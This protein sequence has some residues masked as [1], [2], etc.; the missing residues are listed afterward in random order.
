MSKSSLLGSTIGVL[1]AVSVISYA[2][3]FT[4]EPQKQGPQSPIQSPAKTD[5]GS[6]IDTVS[7]QP[8]QKSSEALTSDR[9]S[10]SDSSSL[11]GNGKGSSSSEGTT[12]NVSPGLAAPENYV[13]TAYSLRGRTASGKPVARGLIAADPS[14]L[15]LGSRVRVE[16]GSLSGEYVVADTGGAVK[17]RHI[18]IWTPTAGEAL[19]FGKR[20]VKLTVLSYGPRRTRP[21]RVT[22]PQNDQ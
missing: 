21:R 12:T 10:G 9:A 13:A 20:A 3:N 4:Q 18:D 1:L 15:P 6:D 16:A 8:T 11:V 19:R 22:K 14:V 7:K 5:I 17:G 2:R